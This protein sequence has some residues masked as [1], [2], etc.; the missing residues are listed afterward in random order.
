MNAK[1][2][3]RSEGGN[4]TPYNGKKLN[5]K[6][7]GP[8]SNH[9]KGGRIK[10]IAGYICLRVDEKYEYEHRVLAE[11]LLGRKLKKGE[12]IHH[13]NEI[14][15]DN[16]NDNIIV[17]P[18]EAV[19]RFLHWPPNCIRQMPNESNRMVLCLCGC[20][21]KLSRFDKRG[22]SCFYISGHGRRSN[23][24]RQI[25]IKD[26]K[27]KRSKTVLE[28]RTNILRKLRKMMKRLRLCP[29]RN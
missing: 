14:K 11:K 15:N 22:R 18:S 20:K 8:L 29:R 10:S 7:T 19:H 26:W 21:R 17:V 23:H 27:L 9:W 6:R 16:K 28:R 24:R 5:S 12:K 3:S 4:L 13:E 25:I 2:L 1:P